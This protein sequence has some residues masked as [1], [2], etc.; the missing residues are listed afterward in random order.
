MIKTANRKA[1][2]RQVRMIKERN[3]ALM[4]IKDLCMVANNDTD[5]NDE[6]IEYI[7]DVAEMVEITPMRVREINQAVNDY[8]ELSHKTKILLEQEN[9]T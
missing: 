8:L 2:L 7:L 1:L 6:E 4:L 3:K 9:W 5:L